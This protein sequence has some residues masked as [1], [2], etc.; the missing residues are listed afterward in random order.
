M[1]VV[2]GYDA[3]PGAVRALDAAVTV[4]LAFDEPLVVV[5]G[6]DP[7]GGRGEEFAEH[8]RALREI[9]ERVVADAVARAA[10]RGVRVEVELGHGR[11]AQ[12]LVDVAARRDAR[13]IVVGSYGEGRVRGALLGSTPY[14]LLGLAD[15]PVLVVPPGE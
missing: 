3:S 1:S 9:G 12:A 2:V 6:V 11:P 4:A 7:P 5:Y 10:D 15:R 13:V 14:R 8:A